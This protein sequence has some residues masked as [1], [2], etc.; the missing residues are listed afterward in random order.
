MAMKSKALRAKKIAL[1]SHWKC[2][3]LFGGHG[4]Y[5]KFARM[6]KHYK[7]NCIVFLEHTK[8][9]DSGKLLRKDH[10]TS[11][12]HCFDCFEL[13][14]KQQKISG[15]KKIANYHL[16]YFKWIC[17]KAAA[18]RRVRPIPSDTMGMVLVATRYYH[19]LAMF[20]TD[21]RVRF[22]SSIKS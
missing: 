21:G 20:V 22:I 12:M 13:A 19:C 5:K 2:T 4:Q 10:F 7:K 14:E 8:Y 18:H 1:F 17:E 3:H 9:F 16:D 11:H 15:V 6:I